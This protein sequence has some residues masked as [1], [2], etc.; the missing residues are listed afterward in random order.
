MDTKKCYKCSQTKDVSEF[1]KNKRRPD[2]L[3]TKCR[4]CSKA[5]FKE[6][7]QSNDQ[8]YRDKNQQR[9]I[10]IV[11]FLYDYLLQHPC[12]D[13]G[14][15]EP[16]CLDFDHRDGVEK[17]FGLA[18]ARKHMYSIERLMEEI[19]KCDVKCANCH[20][21]R[22]AKQQNWY[23]KTDQTYKEFMGT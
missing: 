1:N 22:T 21:K 4:E 13:C 3:Q 23:N 20:R 15:T 5:G 11:Q 9:R 7:Y 2:G 14:E 12:V 19:A 18:L 16:A 8:Y 6:H 17:S 10:A